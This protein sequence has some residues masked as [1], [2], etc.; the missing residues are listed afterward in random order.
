MVSPSGTMGRG[1]RLAAFASSL[2]VNDVVVVEATGNAA[3]VAE[4]SVPT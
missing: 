3:S 4:A 2:P 1:D